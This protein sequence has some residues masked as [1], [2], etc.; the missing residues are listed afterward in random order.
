MSFKI[1]HVGLN[2]TDLDRSKRFYLHVFGF[3]LL[4]ESTEGDRRYATLGYDGGT[5]LTLWQQSEGRFATASPGLHHLAFQVP[6]MDA[7]REAE[8]TLQEIGVRFAYDGLVSHGEGRQSGG[9]FFEDP[10]GIRVEISA[11]TGAED[12]KAPAAG[13]PTCG[14]F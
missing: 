14:F 10:D 1:G 5:V 4:K 8:A 7:V 12:L 9:V 13:A 6:D 2:V 11:P 3:D